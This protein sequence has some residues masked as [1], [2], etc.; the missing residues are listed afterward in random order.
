[1]SIK[2]CNS[3]FL[4]CKQCAWVERAPSPS[5]SLHVVAIYKPSLGWRVLEVSGPVLTRTS[6]MVYEGCDFVR[7]EKKDE[8]EYKQQIV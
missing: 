3:D 1:M 5:V 2:V 6:R 4:R 8:A 7:N